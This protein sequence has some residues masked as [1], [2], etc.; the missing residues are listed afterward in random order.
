MFLNKMSFWNDVR[1]LIFVWE[2][3][4]RNLN[5]K[6]VAPSSSP[7]HLVTEEAGVINKVVKN[8]VS[9]KQFDNRVLLKST[10][11]LAKRVRQT[12]GDKL[13]N[14]CNKVAI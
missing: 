7:I 10:V 13:E 4:I 5:W 12:P 2:T 6:L 9:V 3:L 14:E 8:V 11:R 1:V